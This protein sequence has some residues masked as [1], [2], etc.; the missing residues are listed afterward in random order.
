MA[1][2]FPGWIPM[3]QFADAQYL[4]LC[5]DVERALTAISPALDGREEEALPGAWTTAGRILAVELLCELGHSY[6]VAARLAIAEKDARAFRRYAELAREQYR[7]GKSSVLGALYERLVDEARQAGLVDAAPRETGAVFNASTSRSSND[8]TSLL[9]VCQDPRERAELALGLLCD[10]DPPT[11]G[12]LLVSKGDGLVLVA[13][14]TACAST[15]E[16]VSFAS[17]RMDRES[18]A[19]SMET[20]ASALETM[21]TPWTEWRDP[22]GVDYEV[23]LLVTSAP[24][25]FCI[26]GVALL[27]KSGPPRGGNLAPLADAIARALITSGD[28]VAVDAA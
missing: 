12:H 9:A 14:N 13:S 21:G 16:I 19:G 3:L 28:A 27:A 2:R 8:L 23:V 1:A 10:G 17:D 24:D 20:N 5:G 7:P 25:G 22:D 26:A 4:R 15:S 6:E 11:R 18:R